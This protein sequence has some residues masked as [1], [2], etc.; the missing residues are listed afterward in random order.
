MYRIKKYIR[1][2]MFNPTIAGAFINPFYFA[3]KG[4]Y[5]AM[6]RFV[7]KLQGKILDVGCGQKPYQHLCDAKKVS[8]YIGLE[9]DS[10]E[11]RTNKQADYFYD[12]KNFP[13]ENREFDS[14]M[15]N[16]VLEHVFN[17][18]EFLAEINRILK[19][20]GLLLLTVPFVWD[21]HEQPFDYARYS[22]FGL[23]HL[24]QK[25]GF[26]IIS[27][28]KTSTDVS[29]IFQL[30]NAYLFKILH[31]NNPYFNI[32]LTILLISPFNVIG[33]IL[34]KILP[35]NQDLYLDNIVLA[36]KKT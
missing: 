20:E 16:Q 23:K 36:R 35:D 8:E 2:Q 27:H 1:Q 4:L 3:R 24:L 33:I 7:P 12:G 25:Q 5:K 30:I 15:T 9:I 6:S 13:F 14:V 34:A 18:D 10:T 32:I 31:T 28:I 26:E 22:S 17:P 19:P 29:V 21:E 11:N